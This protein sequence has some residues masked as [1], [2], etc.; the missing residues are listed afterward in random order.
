M[1]PG[2]NGSINEVLKDH[3]Y[4]YPGKKTLIASDPLEIIAEDFLIRK[5]IKGLDTVHQKIISLFFK[6]NFLIIA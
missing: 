4:F 6:R 3:R 5:R 1:A 2:N